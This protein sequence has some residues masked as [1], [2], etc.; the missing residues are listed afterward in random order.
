MK[1]NEKKIAIVPGSFDPI[2]YGHIDIAKRAAQCYDKV[3]FAVMINREKKYLFSIE[4]RVEIAKAALSE[5]ENIEVI[6]SEGMLWE[7]AQK[8]S[9]NAIV[10]GYRNNIDLEYENKMAKYNKEHYP[11]AETVL[12]KADEKLSYISSTVVREYLSQGKDL[13][14]YLPEAAISVIN[15]LSKKF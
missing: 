12:L 9:A 1:K 5:F 3:Y 14:G 7:L 10:K 15:K 11:N 8:L 4:E 6:S 13:S 2:T